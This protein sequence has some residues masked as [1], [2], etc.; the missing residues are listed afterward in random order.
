MANVGQGFL[1]HLGFGEEINYGTAVARPYF[2]EINSESISKESEIIETN[3][4]TRRG[5]INLRVAPGAKR[6]SG[7]IE[8]DA[9]YGGWLKLAK[10]SFGQIDTSSPDP[11]N[12][13]TARRHRFTIADSLPTG[14]T[15]ELYRDN[16][17]FVTEPNKA[18]VYAGCK[19]NTME[20][21]C[22]VDEILK[23]GVGIMGQDESR[24]TKTATNFATDPL[25]VY[26]QGKLTWNTTEL[27]VEQFSIQINN[28]L[29]ARPKL[30][31]RVTR[32]PRPSDQIEVTG[33]FMTEF[34]SWAEY[35]DFLNASERV[36]VVTFTG[37]LIAGST[38]KQIILTANVAIM[39]NNGAR[40]VLDSPGRLKIEHEFKCYRSAS[41]NELVLDVINTETG[42]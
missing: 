3:A 26:H 17:S 41:A 24:A 31:S 1:S 14:L 13:P 6:I 8:F 39:R 23:V 36:M 21:S 4:I 35:D 42:I 27:E 19:I 12:A 15:M 5:I 38:Y 33:T 34:V 20:F 40:V 7:D 37:P 9:Q 29:E 11:T 2:V 18:F 10:H 25:A 30:N 16:S 32:E 22:G 28:N